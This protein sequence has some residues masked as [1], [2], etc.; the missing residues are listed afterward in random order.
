MYII[1]I[2]MTLL[3]EMTAT[4]VPEIFLDFSLD[5]SPCVR[6]VRELQSSG[7]ETQEKPLRPEGR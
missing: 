2:L 7:Q 5:F 1:N 6:A 3:L 4:L